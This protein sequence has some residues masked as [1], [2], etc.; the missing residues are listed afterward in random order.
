[1]T[2]LFY[3]CQCQSVRITG[4][5]KIRHLVDGSKAPQANE[6][7]AAVEASPLPWSSARDSPEKKVKMVSFKV[8]KYKLQKSY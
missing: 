6:V 3:C 2:S 8:Y 4:V 5:L 7:A 1:M